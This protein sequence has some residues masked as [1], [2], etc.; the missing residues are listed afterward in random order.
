MAKL[1][2]P[3]QQP[4]RREIKRAMLNINIQKKNKYKPLNLLFAKHVNTV[5]I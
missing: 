2:I 4:K 3:N 5:N 1:K